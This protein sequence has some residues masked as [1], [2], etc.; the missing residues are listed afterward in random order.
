MEAV[1]ADG[2]PERLIAPEQMELAFFLLLTHATS[3]A[4]GKAAL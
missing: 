2:L 4:R 3:G 1:K